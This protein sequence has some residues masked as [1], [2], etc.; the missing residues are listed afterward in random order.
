MNTLIMALIFLCLALAGLV[1]WL[2]TRLAEL[3]AKCRWLVDLGMELDPVDIDQD[4]LPFE[5]IQREGGA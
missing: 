4:G 2:L 1:G 3:D 5:V